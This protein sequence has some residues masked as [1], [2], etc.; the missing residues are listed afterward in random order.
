MRL[1]IGIDHANLFRAHIAAH[2]RRT[3]GCQ[4]W[5]V[6]IELI[7]VNGTLH[8]HFPQPQCGGDKD[9]LIK[10]GLGINGEHHTRGGQV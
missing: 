3:I 6:H 7:G 2:N 9:H 4:G 8:H 5:L 1:G 10:A